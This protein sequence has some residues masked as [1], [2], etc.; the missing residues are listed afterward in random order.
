M[1]M[2]PSASKNVLQWL[3]TVVPEPNLNYLL[4]FECF[5]FL[6]IP[7]SILKTTFLIV[8]PLLPHR[9]LNNHGDGVRAHACSRQATCTSLTPPVPS[10]PALWP[11]AFVKAWVSSAAGAAA[12]SVLALQELLGV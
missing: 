6:S 3:L 5:P 2:L 11:A 4:K 10:A 8:N 7:F 9:A 12:V 1:V